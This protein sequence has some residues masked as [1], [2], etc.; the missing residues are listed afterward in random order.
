MPT[1]FEELIQDFSAFEEVEAI[2]LAGSR[3]NHSNDAHSDYDVYVYCTQEVPVAKRRAVTARYCSYIEINNQFWETEDDGIFNDGTPLEIIYRNFAWLTAELD[4]VVCQ[5]QARTGYTTCFWSNIWHS[6]ILY[7]RAGRAQEL[8]E[9]YRQPYP[10]ELQR[11]II[12][13][14]YPLLRDKMPAY[15]H[16]I[17]KAV[18]RGDVVSVHHRLTEFLASYFDILF[19]INAYLHPGEKRLIQIANANC[20]KL[21]VDFEPNIRQLLAFAGAGD[22]K[23][24]AAIN[25]TVDHLDKLLQQAQLW[26]GVVV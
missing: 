20:P 5:H 3:A 11:N 4:R 22:A 1:N 13:K 10:A 16:Q 26:S 15:A 18:K 17:E 2:L 7:D 24:V 9:R 25:T 12:R 19:A 21:P 8:Q 23:I 14:N 6:N